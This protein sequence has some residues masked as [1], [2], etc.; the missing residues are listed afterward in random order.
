M[1]KAVLDACVLYPAPLRDVLLSIAGV[2]C[3]DPYWSGLITDEWKRNLL[4]NRPDLKPEQLDKTIQV[5]DA[6]FPDAGLS[7]F[8]SHI[9]KVKLPDP[10][11][12]HVVA[13]ALS[14]GTP[15]IVTNNLADF[16]SKDLKAYSITAI[17]PD[18]F[19]E[20]LIVVDDMLEL[21]I[22]ALSEQRSRL[23]KP[24][25]GVEDFISTIEQQ[26]LKKLAKRLLLRKADL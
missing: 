13:A 24:P 6:A 3:F 11:D 18:N 21:I 22:G 19:I 23:K 8:E 14:S 7:G 2:G 10:D 9:S 15:Y 1:K 20:D 17:S 4:Q 16:P 12:R 26:G 25:V 5:M